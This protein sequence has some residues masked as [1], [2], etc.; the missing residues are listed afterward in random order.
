MPP[1]NL[2]SFASY[3]HCRKEYYWVDLDYDSF[4]IMNLSTSK[5][6]NITFTCFSFIF[7]NKTKTTCQMSHRTNTLKH[8]ARFLFPFP[9]RSSLVS[10]FY[11]IF[12]LSSI[13]WLSVRFERL[14]VWSGGCF[15]SVENPSHQIQWIFLGLWFRVRVFSFRF[16]DGLKWFRVSDTKSV[17]FVFKN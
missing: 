3:T 15:G 8:K 10:Y 16:Q 17:M 4:L 6:I 1:W 9:F 7:L 13:I 11:S 12:L 5:P 14:W 2:T